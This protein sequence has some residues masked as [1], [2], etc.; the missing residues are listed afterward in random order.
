MSGDVPVTEVRSQ[1]RR[2]RDGILERQR[3][4]ERLPA[5]PQIDRVNNVGNA[6]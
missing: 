4:R 1:A 3:H 5:P 2:E 6:P